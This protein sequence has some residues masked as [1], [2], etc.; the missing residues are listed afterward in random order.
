M[1][2]LH[3]DMRGLSRTWARVIDGPQNGSDFAVAV[4]NGFGP[5]EFGNVRYVWLAATVFN[6]A[7]AGNDIMAMRLEAANPDNRV[8]VIYPL[9]GIAGSDAAIDIAYNKPCLFIGARLNSGTSANFVTVKYPWHLENTPS[10]PESGM[11]ECWSIITGAAGVYDSPAAIAI[12]TSAEAGYLPES[13]V[14]AGL[15]TITGSGA[16]MGTFRFRQPSPP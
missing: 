12:D 5:E 8:S 7:A 9:G 10:Q 13:V 16:N 11:P 4:V 15:V 14:A 2:V 1:L 6:G 3:F